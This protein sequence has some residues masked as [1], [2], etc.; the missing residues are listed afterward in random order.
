MVWR[1]VIS[2]SAAYLAAKG[3]PEAA[4]AALAEMPGVKTAATRGDDVRVVLA[5][6]E[7]EG[8]AFL[9]ELVRRDLKPIS[10]LPAN[11]RL[12]DLYLSVTKGV[13]A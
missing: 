1:D 4:V 2:K 10:F 8:A 13:L 11:G 12:E 6:D 7:P 9:A 3:V 5:G